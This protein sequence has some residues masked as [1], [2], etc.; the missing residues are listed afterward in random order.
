MKDFCLNFSPFVRFSVETKNDKDYDSFLYAY[1]FRLFYSVD[2]KIDFIVNNEDFSINSGELIVIPPAVGYKLLFNGQ[3]VKYF[4]FNFDFYS[5]NTAMPERAPVVREEFCF[6]EVRTDLI[7]DFFSRG[8]VFKNTSGIKELIYK[9]NA[10][11]N[12]FINGSED[13][14]SLLLKAVFVKLFQNK[15]FD[16]GVSSVSMS[17]KNFIDERYADCIDNEVVAKELG[18]HPYYLGTVFKKAF[19]MTLHAY[20]TEVKLRHARTLL[21]ETYKTVSEISYETG[22]SNPSYFSEMFKKVYSLTPTEFRKTLR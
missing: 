16:K 1:D 6:S 7:P 2:G 18:Y 4:I 8:R 12:V 9:I 20:I 13:F 21:A 14:K 11:H 3:T 15:D 10:E 5:D 17:A 19:G 22:F